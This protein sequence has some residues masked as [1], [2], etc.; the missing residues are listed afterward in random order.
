VGVR[1]RDGRTFHG[2]SVILAAP[3]HDVAKTAAARMLRDPLVAG[4]AKLESS[5]VIN[6][7]FWFD[8]KVS[9]FTNLMFSPGSSCRFTPTSAKPRTDTAGRRDRSSR[10]ASRRPTT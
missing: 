9:H 7:H 10:S 1:T 8:R 5:P 4:V 6:G 3:V 2:R